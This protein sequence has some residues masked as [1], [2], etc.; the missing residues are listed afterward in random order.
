MLPARWSLRCPAGRVND[1]QAFG[2]VA[3]AG[4]VPVA[5]PSARAEGRAVLV[6]EDETLVAL[7]LAETLQ[8]AGFAVLGPAAS[9]DE[10]IALLDRSG[11]ALAILDVNLGNGTTSLP[12]A[13][14]LRNEGLPFFVTS[15]Y[16][17]SQKD[18]VFQEARNFPKPVAAAEIIAAARA[19]LAAV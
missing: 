1:I 7:E 16:A 13:A 2:P 18:P 4:T 9:V 12:I 6:V 3:A 11:C 14:R 19:V 10:A 5:P 15:G 8:E 17:M